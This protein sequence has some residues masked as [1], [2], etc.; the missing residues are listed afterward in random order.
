[1]TTQEDVTS[2]A[3]PDPD[4]EPTITVE[5][6]ATV[7]GIGRRTAYAAAERGELPSVRVG[8][9]IRIPTARFLRQYGFIE[10]AKGAA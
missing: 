9:C 3:L 7:L 4:R 5:R 1:M 2:T 8:R 6:A 10:P